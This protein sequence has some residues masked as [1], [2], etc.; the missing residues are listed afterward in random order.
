M[1][2]RTYSIAVI[3]L[4]VLT[5]CSSAPMATGGEQ[6]A[7]PEFQAERAADALP[8]LPDVLAEPVT[9]GLVRVEFASGDVIHQPGIYF[10][11]TETGRGEGWVPAQPTG[12][13]YFYARVADDNRFII[14]SCTPEYDCIFDREAGTFWRWSAPFAVYLADERGVLFGEQVSEPKQPWRTL[15]RL[16]WAG[17]DMRP[18]YTFRLH[19]GEY[20]LR[21]SF[22][23]PDGQYLALLSDEGALVRFDLATGNLKTLATFELATGVRQTMALVEGLIQVTTRTS[24]DGGPPPHWYERVT[25]YD[26]DGSVIK[27]IALPGTRATFSPDGQWITWEEWPQDGLAPMTVVGDA[28]TL[29][30]R[31]QALGATTCFAMLDSSGGS[32]W[33]SDSSGLVVDSGDGYRLLTLDGELR[34]LP[35]F[36][37]LDWRFEPVPAPDNPDLFALGRIAVSDGAGTKQLGITLD[38]FVTPFGDDPWGPDSTEMRFR[39]PPK[40]GGGACVEELPV[41]P[42]VRMSGDP[43]H[44]FPL[45]VDGVD[46]CLP[47]N[48][49]EF[50]TEPACLPNGTRVTAYRPKPDRSAHYWED[51]VQ[52]LWVKTEHGQIGEISLA[53]RPLRWAVE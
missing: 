48:P 36:E 8:P 19:D 10:L 20:A 31:L 9:D 41:A 30:P 12:V 21:D 43:L 37:G 53:G 4:C 25:R 6:Q 46:G 45:V 2:M 15:G 16:I 11:N 35:A 40:P 14:A 26:W 39:V 18:L 34:R 17:P 42:A 51:G 52:Y 49:G 3:L 7:L 1:K 44:E 50:G 33:L 22:L 29:E 47:L 38:G 24:K 5:A 28:K 23:S 32:R 27:D 13:D